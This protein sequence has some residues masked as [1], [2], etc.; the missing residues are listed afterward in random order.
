M[1]R[2]ERFEDE[3]AIIYWLDGRMHHV[4]G[5]AITWN[6]GREWSWRLFGEA[7]RY[8]GPQNQGG[9]WCIRGGWV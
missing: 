8:Y 1:I 9:D 6:R 2:L 3:Y 4:N 7:H 5:P